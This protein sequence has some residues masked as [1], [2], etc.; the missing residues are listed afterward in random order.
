M[1]HQA[2]S[3]CARD[4]WS[5][6]LDTVQTLRGQE[7]VGNILSHAVCAASQDFVL[8]TTLEPIR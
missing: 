4:T 6:P 3:V 1:V 2:A 8:T 7:V 5:R